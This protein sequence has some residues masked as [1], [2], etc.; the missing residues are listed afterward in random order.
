MLESVRKPNIHR[1]IWI[2]APL[3]RIEVEIKVLAQTSMA[4]VDLQAVLDFF[5]HRAC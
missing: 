4:A 3:P 5:T 1:R 2:V